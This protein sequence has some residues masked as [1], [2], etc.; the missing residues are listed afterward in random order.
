MGRRNSLTPWNNLPTTLA[1]AL[2][3]FEAE[4]SEDNGFQMLLGSPLKEINILKP[5][6][7]IAA[8]ALYC[9]IFDYFPYERPF[10]HPIATSL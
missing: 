10:R 3:Q 6:M 8:E 1:H 2:V 9:S 4:F 7:H 5:L